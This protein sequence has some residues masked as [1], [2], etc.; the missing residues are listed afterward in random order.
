MSLPGHTTDWRDRVE[1]L[2]GGLDRGEEQAL[3]LLSPQQQQVQPS[4]LSFDGS[5]ADGA[6]S[7]GSRHLTSSQGIN[8]EREEFL[9]LLDLFVCVCGRRGFDLS[10]CGAAAS[11]DRSLLS[12]SRARARSSP[13]IG[14]FFVFLFLELVLKMDTD[15]CALSLSLHHP[16][17]HLPYGVSLLASLRLFRFFVGV[18][19][20]HCVSMR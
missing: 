13:L 4:S 3:P 17:A 1:H 8:D 20:H 11:E 5:D 7:M 16:D 19:G 6:R 14:G 2:R 18:S 9:D 15:T 10:E 12:L